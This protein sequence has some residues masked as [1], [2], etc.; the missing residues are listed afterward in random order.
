MMAE[1]FHCLSSHQSHL[2]EF[3]SIR[4]QHCVHHPETGAF[5]HVEPHYKKHCLLL[6]LLS[7]SAQAPA[8][9]LLVGVASADITPAGP[10]ALVGQFNL[11][12]ARTV[13]T[14]L[15][16][17]VVVLESRDGERSLDAAVMVSC[18]LIGIP[19]EVLRLVREEVQ[20]RLPDL[21]T[22]KI[23]LNGTHTHTAPVLEPGNYVHSQGGR[24]A[25]RGVSG[26]SGPAGCRGDREGV[27]RPQAG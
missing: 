6:S 14:P 22:K 26:L 1:K 5:C 21:D 18:D 13:E 9:E 12:I 10:V 7:W 11:R 24:H 27:E 2:P 23:F 19:A 25:G 3:R 17:N 4:E 20:K 8:A 16:A 15:T